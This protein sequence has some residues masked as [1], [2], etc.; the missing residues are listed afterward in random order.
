MGYLLFDDMVEDAQLIIRGAKAI[1]NLA[2]SEGVKRGVKQMRDMGKDLQ[3]KVSESETLKDLQSGIS[4]K[5]SESE[6]LKN[7]QEKVSESETLKGLQRK[8]GKSSL[9]SSFGADLG[10]RL[11][12]SKMKRRTICPN[13]GSMARGGAVFCSKC[14]TSLEMGEEERD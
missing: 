4:R 5:V 6:A 13:C 9:F 8:V 10:E 2:K 12:N 14:G 3:E 7:L 1:N 11:S